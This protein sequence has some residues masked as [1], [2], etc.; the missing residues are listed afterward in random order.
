MQFSAQ[1]S[2]MDSRPCFR[3]LMSLLLI[4]TSWVVKMFTRWQ[5]QENI[6][7]RGF[8]QVCEA[9]GHPQKATGKKTKSIPMKIKYSQFLQ[10]SN[11]YCWIFRSRNGN[12]IFRV[13]ND[14]SYRTSMTTQATS[15]WRPRYPFWRIFFTEWCYPIPG[16]LLQVI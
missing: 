10:T 6:K 5:S 7:L 11:L 14:T 13:K 2:K 12:T 15:F 4:G 9:I 1:H 3:H 8:A 16:F